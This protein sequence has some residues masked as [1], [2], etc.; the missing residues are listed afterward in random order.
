ME[1]EL[2]AKVFK[3]RRKG[4][5]FTAANKNKYEPDIGYSAEEHLYCSSQPSVFYYILIND[6]VNVFHL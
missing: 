1:Q 6:A 3:I 4:L 2:Y 5:K